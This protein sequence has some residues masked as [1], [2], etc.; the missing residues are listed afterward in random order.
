MKKISLLIAIVSSVAFSQLRV[1]VD[2]SREMDMEIKLMGL[3]MS[4]TD[5]A[6]GMGLTIGYEK[7][8]LLGMIGA[9]AEYNLSMGDEDGPDPF[10]FAYGVVKVPVGFPMVRG[11]VR[12][13]TTLGHSEGVKGAG[14]YGFGLRVKPPIQPFGLEAHYTIHNIDP[15]VEDLDDMMGMDVSTSASMKYFNITMTY[16]F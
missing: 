6:E 11:I 9:G 8:L 4:E 15:N 2:L 5:K 16:S 13:G 14:S 7:M 10:A 3:E 12:V 1:G